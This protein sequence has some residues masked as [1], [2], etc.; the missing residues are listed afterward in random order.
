MEIKAQD[1]PLTFSSL[2]NKEKVGTVVYQDWHI[3][4][5]P[6]GHAVRRELSS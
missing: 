6:P 2:L 3:I 5:I 1:M 4:L